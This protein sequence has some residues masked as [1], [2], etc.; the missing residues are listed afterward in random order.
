MCRS[1]VGYPGLLGG[2]FRYWY[3]EQELL[4]LRSWTFGGS[5]VGGVWSAH[6]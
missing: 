1:R 4:G 3:W 6:P 5:W 2:H